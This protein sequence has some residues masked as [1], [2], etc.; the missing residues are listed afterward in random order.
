MSYR[1]NQAAQ[2]PRPRLRFA[3]SGL[4]SRP[5][6]APPPPRSPHESRI[7]VAPPSAE[8]GEIARALAPAG[9]ELVLVRAAGRSSRPR[10]GGRIRAVLS[11]PDHERRV[12]PGGAAAAAGAAAQRRLRQRR[13]RGGAARAG[14]HRQQRRRQRHLGRRARADADA[15]GVAPADLDPCQR[16]GRA[17]ARQRAL[18]ACTSSSTR[19][20]ASSG[21]A[22]SARR[23][24]GWRAR[25]ACGSST[26]TSRGL[27][28]TPRTRSA[29][30]SGCCA[31]CCGA[32]TSSR[33]TC[34]ST[35]RPA[36]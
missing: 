7:I 4:Q 12:L 31:S 16:G 14:A 21:S 28:R 15:H 6:P 9:Y 22:P 30:A 13:S 19:R 32:P 24:L 18:R 5:R 25:S 29:C 8:T 26:T 36:T 20:S 34:R 10:W 3:P 33:C 27:T 2:R 23:W 35:P 1:R 11:E 17:L